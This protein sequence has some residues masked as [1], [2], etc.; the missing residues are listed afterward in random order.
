MTEPDDTVWD[1]PVKPGTEEW[2]KFKSHDE[3]VESC[4]I[5]E[6]ILSSLPTE[7]LAKLCLRYPLL[8]D[9]FAFNST[10]YGLDKLFKEFNGIRE[11]YEREDAPE[12]LTGQY[13]RKVQ[14]FSF[15]ERKVSDSEKGEFIISV[16]VLEALLSRVEMKN[17]A[18]RKACKKILQN[19]VSGYEG[20]RRYANYFAGFGL[21]TNFYSRA[22]MIRKLDGSSIESLPQKEENAVFFS[23]MVDGQ[24]A[25]IIDSLSYQLIK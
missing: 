6:N 7:D 8:I 20:K 21:R 4:Q 25:N 2:K 12:T 18:G 16:S 24:S 10:N 23:G 17:D 14:G 9:I 22:W 13:A 19:L 3:M 5:P 1:Y 11:F 15:L